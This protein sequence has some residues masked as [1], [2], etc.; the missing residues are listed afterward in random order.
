MIKIYDSYEDEPEDVF[1]PLD[2]KT[3]AHFYNQE[4]KEFDAD[5][6]FYTKALIPSTKILELGCGGGRLSRQLIKQG[7]HLTGID[8][9]TE[10]LEVARKAAPQGTFLTANICN[11]SI[12]NS[13]DA[14]IAPY[15]VLNLLPS[16]EDIAQCLN[17]CK[18]HLG[19]EG[20]FLMEIY[21]QDGDIIDG[22]KSFQFQVFPH[23]KGGRLVK[24]IVRTQSIDSVQVEERYRSRP[25]AGE[26]TDYSHTFSINALSKGFW[27]DILQENGFYILSCDHHYPSEP[28]KNTNNGRTLITAKV[29]K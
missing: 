25:T 28:Q 9:S 10:M 29:Q 3:Y 16:K 19:A 22:E 26:F 4:M 12:N 21:T 7:Y 17:R 24:E 15:N 8:L 27:Q 2:E 20:L 5:L 1:L 23:P 14:V 6:S 13:F 18:E 11:F